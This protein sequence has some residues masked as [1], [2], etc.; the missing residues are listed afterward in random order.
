MAASEKTMTAKKIRES[1]VSQL[2][3]MD[4]DVD[5]YR[6]MVDDYCWMWQQVHEMKA[7]IKRNGRVIDTVSASGK[8]YSKEN[9][10]VKNA[11]LYSRQMV[12]ILVSLGIKPGCGDAGG[13]D[14]EL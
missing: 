12:S 2:Q 13:D 3:M 6:S 14:D 5:V 4:A 8:P 1:L 7:D 11:L 10:S 9:P